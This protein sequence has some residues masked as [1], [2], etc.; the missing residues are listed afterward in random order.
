MCRSDGCSF[1][2]WKMMKES[3]CIG[4]KT[5]YESGSQRVID[6]IINKKLDLKIAKKQPKNF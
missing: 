3:G 6:K 1:E 2:K 4:V 5:G